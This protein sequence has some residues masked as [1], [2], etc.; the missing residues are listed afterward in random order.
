MNFDEITFRNWENVDHNSIE[1]E[2]AP[3]F[4]KGMNHTLMI[5]SSE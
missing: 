1:L 2:Q 3:G 4:L 5:H